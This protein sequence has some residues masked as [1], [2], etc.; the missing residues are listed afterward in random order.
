M[1]NDE[2]EYLKIMHRAKLSK[3]AVHTNNIE[4]NQIAQ[5]TLTKRIRGD[6]LCQQFQVGVSRGQE[7][8]IETVML[9]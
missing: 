7:K 8:R 4:E 3:K 9:L 2:Y 1:H 6:L 5:E